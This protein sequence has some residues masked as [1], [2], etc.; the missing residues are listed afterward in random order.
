MN[1]ED[2]IETSYEYQDENTSRWLKA[3]KTFLRVMVFVFS[4]D[5]VRFRIIYCI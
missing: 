2:G 4:I 5:F 1:N 3:L